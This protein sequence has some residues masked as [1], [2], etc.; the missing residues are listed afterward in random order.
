M[1]VNPTEI[2][3][4]LLAAGFELYRTQGDHVHVAD[5]VRDNLIMDSGVSVS[6]AL[7]VKFVVRSQRSD[8]PND[9]TAMLFE[10]ARALAA[11]ALTRGYLETGTVTNPMH[12]PADP[13]R[14]LDTWYEISFEKP[15][16]TLEEAMTEVG[17]ALGIEKTA[18]TAAPTSM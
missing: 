11:P 16:T 6:T 1:S 12:D 17:F 5:R 2:R 13:T 8:F 9:A 18:R 3:K 10:R 15:V 7:T 14:T 4:A